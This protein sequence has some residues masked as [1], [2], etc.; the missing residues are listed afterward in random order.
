MGK[1]KFPRK[2]IP[3]VSIIIPMYNAEK[4]VGECL[5]SILAQTFTDYEVIVVDDCSTDNS[6]AVVE[7]YKK[8]FGGKLQLINRAV[9]SGNPGPPTNDGIILSRGEY[10]WLIDSDDAIVKTALEELVS[11]AKKF[12]ADVVHCKRYYRFPADKKYSD[13]SARVLNKYLLGGEEDP[14]AL[15]TDNLLERINSLKEGKF[16]TNLWT[17]LIRR[18]FML[19][20][21]IELINGMAQDMLSTTCIIL[22]APRYL[23][24]PNC[25]NLYRVVVDSHSHSKNTLDKH[26]HKWVGSM[27][28]GFNYFDKFLSERKVFQEYPD[29]KFS[30]LDIWVHECC[31]YFIKL[32]TQFPIHQL[33]SLIREEFE[34][35]EDT[36]KVAAFLFSRMNIFNLNFNKQTEVVKNLQDRIDKS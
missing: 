11:L 3:A 10:L 16:F 32:Y 7:S 34:K 19:Q 4:Y 31:K 9:N 27:I 23:L 13:T 29:L 1:E 25:V 26:I 33:D 5:D 8:K 22:T 2:T 17:K 12:D 36:K 18:N 20:N 30:A 21:R 24:V 14:P 15:L 28:R 6:R 35:A